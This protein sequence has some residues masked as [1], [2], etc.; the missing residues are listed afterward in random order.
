MDTIKLD[1]TWSHVVLD[2]NGDILKLDSMNL[3]NWHLGDYLVE[4]INPDESVYVV[5]PKE[6]IQLRSVD[7][8]I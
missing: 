7:K 1:S 3:R 6:I 4:F 8:V 5:S 2:V